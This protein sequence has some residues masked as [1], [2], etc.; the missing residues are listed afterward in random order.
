MGMAESMRRDWDERARK[1]AF[2]YI[3]SWRKDWDLSGFLQSGED[4]YKRLVLPVLERF[5]FSTE[6]KTMLELGC[7][8]GRMTH[9]FSAHFG[10]VFAFD[11][12]S[13]MLQRARE[14]LCDK[15]NIVWVQGNGVDLGGMANESADFVFSYLVLQHLPDQKL[16]CAYIGEMLRVLKESGLCLFQVNGLTRPN[17]NWKGRLAWGLIDTLWAVRLP[18]LS[19]AVSHL[20]GFDPEMGG[21][22]W[23]G[24]AVTSQ[25]IARALNASGGT[26]LEVQGENTAMVWFCARKGLAQGVAG[27]FVEE[28]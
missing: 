15:E 26:V 10:R 16:V 21:K 27:S 7:G 5:D 11:V 24:T 14:L 19:R 4:D 6:G 18:R 25:S 12:S 13:Q 1:D 28:K 17:M 2:Y 20:L 9:S 22:S 8:A 23:H 3:A